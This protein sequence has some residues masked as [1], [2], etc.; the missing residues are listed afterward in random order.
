[1]S[2][3]TTGA[4]TGSLA[5]A[6]LRNGVIFLVGHYLFRGNEVLWV[7]IA[8]VVGAA[9]GASGMWLLRHA[10]GGSSLLDIV[11]RPGG[12]VRFRSGAPAR[13]ARRTARP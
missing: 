5:G 3:P 1:M 6:F 2:S 4:A 10:R 13:Q 9:A 11:T 7:A 12:W 8:A